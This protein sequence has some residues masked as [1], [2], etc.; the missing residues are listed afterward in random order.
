MRRKSRTLLLAF[1]L[2]A[3]AAARSASGPAAQMTPETAEKRAKEAL[4]AS[5]K[6][7][8]ELGQKFLPK[9]QN[10]GSGWLLP[11][12]L[13]Q[14]VKKIASEE[15]YW[16]SL[17]G[18]FDKDNKAFLAAMTSIF[19]EFEPQELKD[20]LEF[21]I[22]MATKD[23]SASQIP[24]GYSPA[25]FALGS[26]ILLLRWEFSPSLAHK[27]DMV[28]GYLE[29]MQKV[30]AKAA[31]AQF[32]SGSKAGAQAPPDGEKA[33]KELLLR[34][35]KGQSDE[36]LKQGVMTWAAAVKDMTAMT[37]AQCDNWAAL[38]AADEKALKNAHFRQVVVAL[39]VLDRN[40]M[41]EVIAD[42][43]P[44][45]AA[46]LQLRLNSRLGGFRNFSF[47]VLQKKRAAEVQKEM[48]EEKN[49]ERFKEMQQALARLPELTARMQK[50]MPK[51]DF[52]V[53]TRDF[54]DNCYIINMKGEFKLPELAWPAT[55]LQACLRNGNAVVFI[56]LGGNYTPEQLKKELD[57]FLSEMDARTAFFRQ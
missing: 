40:K 34:P 24:E 55:N 39:S 52:E 3:L 47:D 31:E 12:Q 26:I 56:G 5:Y 15:E 14:A 7:R 53:F 29:D 41:G 4:A 44:K 2:L 50:E 45:A 13:P 33:M 6:S 36:K 8:L 19:L 46:D 22:S 32:G 9:P 25:Q 51:V 48:D 57:I 43:T 28:T 37:Y 35:V 42:L 11:W 18:G 16:R 38:Q 1:T 27:M 23:M 17:A 10:L 49:P 20:F 30:M 21:W 54:G